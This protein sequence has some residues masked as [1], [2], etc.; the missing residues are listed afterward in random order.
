[1]I[2]WGDDS[3]LNSCKK[4]GHARY[5]QKVRGSRN[6]LYI[7]KLKVPYKKMHYFPITPRLQR[8]YASTATANEMRWHSEHHMEDG[9]MC[10]PSD[11]PA[12]KHFDGCFPEFSSEV[13]NVRLG[14]FADGFQPFGQSGQ[15]YSLWPVVV[16]P[17]NLP[18]DLCM[19]EEFMFLTV[20]VPGPTNPK[21]KIDVFLQPLIAELKSLWGVGVQT[22][23]IS[24]R[25]NF[26]MR[27][28]LMWTI[29]DF[30]AYSMMSG[31]STAGMLACLHCMEDSDAFR[32]IKSGKQSWFDNHRKFL[33]MNHPYRRNT[34]DF[35]KN[36][37]VTKQFP[38]VRSGDEILKDLNNRGLRKV[39]DVDA[40]VVNAAISKT[41]GWNKRSIFWDL[42]Y[43]REHLLRHNLDVMHIEKNVFD[44]IFNTVFNIPGKTKDTYK[45]RDE[46][47]KYCRRPQ[48][49]QNLVTNKYPDVPFVLNKSQKKD[50]LE[51]VKKLRFPDGY[52]SNLGRCVDAK[53]LKMFGMKSH[54]CHVFMQRLLPIALR[55]FLPN[56][57]WEPITEISLFFKQ[58]TSSSLT[59]EELRN[60][61]EQIPVILCNLEKIFPPSFFDSM[62]H[63]PVHLAYEARI[64][65]PVH[66]RWMYPPER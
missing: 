45:S 20:L 22:Y 10:H 32:L 31:W 4:C 59:D 54:D 65:G 62:E 28:A 64:T 46:L 21:G 1:M 15:Q 2:Y 40:E 27:A 6:R 23:D 58:L 56:R 26:Q 48:F 43:W 3:D 29:N 38:G 16:T 44:N 33:P 30:P 35:I 36:R 53:K 18:P 42:P 39:I 8:L 41:C 19:K 60:L 49:A 55:E 11:A 37:K 50:V 12:W 34:K 52:A 13:R 9:K 24:K 7:R 25:Q 47:N 63:L 66:Y 51:W 5:K 57:I 17:Y 14:L 61:D